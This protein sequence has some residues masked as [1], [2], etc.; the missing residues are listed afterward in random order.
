MQHSAN[1]Y[2]TLQ[3]PAKHTPA[4]LCNTLQHTHL[5]AQM[6][7]WGHLEF[8]MGWLRIAGSL[9][10]QVSFAELI[11]FIGLFCTPASANARL[12]ACRI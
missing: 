4:T 1:P 10:L 9:K 7:D 6:H 12:G 2:N 5:Q 3:H 8:D 11:S